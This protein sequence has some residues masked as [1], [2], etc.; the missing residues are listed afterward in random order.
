MA[1]TRPRPTVQ[2]LSV[3]TAEKIQ[4]A[5]DTVL[6][7]YNC[8]KYD[9]RSGFALNYEKRIKVIN[10]S[11]DPK[12]GVI[13]IVHG[14]D[15]PV[16]TTTGPGIPR[17]PTTSTLIVNNKYIQGATETIKKGIIEPLM[18]SFIPKNSQLSKRNFN[19]FNFHVLCRDKF[20]RGQKVEWHIDAQDQGLGN[21][22]YQIIYYVDTP[23]YKNG[24]VA[25][26]ANRGSLAFLLTRGQPDPVNRRATGPSNIPVIGG[27]L[28]PTRGIGIGFEP[29]SSWHKVL[30]PVTSTELSRKIIVVSVY[31]PSVPYRNMPYTSGGFGTTIERRMNAYVNSVTNAYESLNNNR[32]KIFVNRISSKPFVENVNTN[33]MNGVELVSELSS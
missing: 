22:V 10:G 3:N 31:D 9:S 26:A 33:N 24:R 29:H 23:K 2:T 14:P 27:F 7:T 11:M 12:I 1:N 16:T 4:N 19:N 13:G 18:R 5:F 20:A 28:V 21:P 8:D 30:P 32:K 25:I 17:R 6:Q 15:C